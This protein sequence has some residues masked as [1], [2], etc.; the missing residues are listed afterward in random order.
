MLKRGDIADTEAYAGSYYIETLT[1]FPLVKLESVQ[2]FAATRRRINRAN[3][4]L[5]AAYE[6]ISLPE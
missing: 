3:V 5:H 2:P 6:V 4:H 1:V